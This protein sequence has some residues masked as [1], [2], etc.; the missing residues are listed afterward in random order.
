MQKENIYVERRQFGS[1]DMQITPIGFGAW[2]LGGGDWVYSWGPQDDAESAAAIYHAL[3][4]GIEL[5]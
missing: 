3:D 4:L 2:A 5:D 1:T